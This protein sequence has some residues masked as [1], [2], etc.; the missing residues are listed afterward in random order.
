MF[1]N[2]VKSEEKKLVSQENV[3]SVMKISL[4]D[5]PGADYTSL[6]LAGGVN[7]VIAFVSSSHN[8]SSIVKQLEK[9]LSFAKNRL[10]IQTA[11]LVGASHIDGD[12]YNLN[13]QD[14]III[15]SFSASLIKEVES[16][17]VD[18]LS[19]DIMSDKIS[20]SLDERKNRLTKVIE[21]TVRPSMSINPLDTYILSYFPGLTSSESFFLEAFVKSKI[22]LTNLVGGSAGGGLDFKE[23]NLALNGKITSNSAMIIYC[24]LADGYS[25]DIFTTHNFKKTGAGFDIGE[26]IPEKRNVKSFLIDKKLVSPVQALCEH[27]N[28]KKEDLLNRLQEYSFAIEMGGQLFVRSIASINEDDSINFFCDLYFGENLLLVKGE[29]FNENLKRN[30]SR[31]CNGKEPLTILAND[32]VLRRLN[33][34]ENL[35][36]IDVLNRYPSS[37]FSSFGE[38]SQNLHQNQTLTALCFFKS[39]PDSKMYSNFINTLRTNLAYYG[40]TEKGQ[41]KKVIHIKDTLINEYKKYDQIANASSSNLAQISTKA[42]ENDAYTNKVKDGVENFEEAMDELKT[43]SVNLTNSVE[44]IRES[45][46]QVSAVLQ[47][48]DDIS[49]ETNLLALNATIEAARAGEVG[50]GFAVVAEEVKTLAN[51]VKSSLGEINATFSSINEGVYEIES[52]SDKVLAS[53]NKNNETLR[54]LSESISLLEVESRKTA[55]IAKLSLEDVESSQRELSQ[56]RENISRTQSV[57]DALLKTK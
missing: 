57:N 48:I 47:K 51:N 50:K 1:W 43:L 34:E 44:T 53:T 24:K 8:F 9:H 13:H 35:K 21:S 54:S 27:F 30:F 37:G 7:L 49:D 2:K 28:C 4:Q 12:F 56:I 32:C 3:S 14:S 39:N 10:I 55:Q 31:F 22:P 15:H 18:M 6:E 46:S 16:F 11:G 41:L 23:A 26:C 42:S 33:N 25:Y 29:N 38:V 20:L 36:Y 17:M 40:K 45:T 5:L 19:N 52:S